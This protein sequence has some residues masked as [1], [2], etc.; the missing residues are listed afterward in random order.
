MN[1][2][3]RFAW[4]SLKLAFFLGAIS[5]RVRQFFNLLTN[6]DMYLSPWRSVC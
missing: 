2:K 3:L 5:C 1:N 6:W 4:W